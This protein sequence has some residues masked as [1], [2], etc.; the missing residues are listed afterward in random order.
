MKEIPLTQGYVAVIDDE[1]FERLSGYI[2]RATVRHRKYGNACVYAQRHVRR[3]DGVWTV[4]YM[5]SLISEAPAG[6]VTDH[7]DG[8]GLNNRRANLRVC[9]RSENQ[10]NSRPRGGTS[11]YKGVCWDSHAKKWKAYIA[12]CGKLH[13][14]GLFARETDAAQ[15]YDAA[16][17]KLHG[18][19]ARINTANQRQQAQRSKRG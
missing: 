5:H 2:W 11:R 13:N 19:F 3:G 14:I 8:D 10:H 7:V 1:D 12:V 18:E 15:A 17:M 6:M 16:A 4:Q 9:T